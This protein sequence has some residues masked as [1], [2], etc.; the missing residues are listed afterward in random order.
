MICFILIALSVGEKMHYK[1]LVIES[2]SEKISMLIDHMGFNDIKA[3]VA[4]TESA[5][6]K[7]AIKSEYDLILMNIDEFDGVLLTN[8]ILDKKNVPIIHYSDDSDV[9]D[10]IHS[11]NTGAIDHVLYPFNNEALIS[12][13]KAVCGL[14]KRLRLE[15]L[16]TDEILE[17]RDM[18]IDKVSRRVFIGGVEKVLT[19]REFDLLL[20]FASHPNRVYTREQL[21]SEIWGMKSIGN[22]ATVTVHIKKLREKIETG[23]RDQYI[24]TLW[25][26][27]YRFK[28]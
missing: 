5:A 3:D 9:R 22:I 10:M 12:K 13:I 28:V 16:G 21:F 26:S 17:I 24:E 25:G 14:Y 27:G 6:I 20:F 8:R 4:K 15:C 2:T 1:V 19:T 18:S 11:Y 23:K 7:Q